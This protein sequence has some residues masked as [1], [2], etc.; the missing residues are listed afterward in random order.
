MKALKKFLLGKRRLRNNCITEEY[1][2]EEEF[3]LFSYSR[4][5]PG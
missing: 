3:D 5:E 2:T 4:E 1:H